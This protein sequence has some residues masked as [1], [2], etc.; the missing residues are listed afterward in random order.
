M[1]DPVPPAGSSP[2]PE[3]EPATQSYTPKPGLTAD[4]ALELERACA[5]FE[6]VSEAG[7]GIPIEDVISPHDRHMQN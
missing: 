5:V 7:A 3:R 6:R 4:D 1:S 2:R